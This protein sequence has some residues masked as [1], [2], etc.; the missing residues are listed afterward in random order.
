MI[1]D[2]SLRVRAEGFTLIEL[3]VVISIIAMLI[4]ILLPSMERARGSARL[5]LCMNNLRNIH[6]GTMMYTHDFNDRFPSRWSTGAWAFR[7]APGSVTPG[8]PAALPETFGWAAVLDHHQHLPW[9][10]SERIWTCP[11]Q[12]NWMKDFG[13]TYAFSIAGTLDNLRTMD[14]RPSTEILWDN[15]SIHPGLTGF[16]GPFRGY[17]IPVAERFY[18]HAEFV[19]PVGRASD[20][21][22][23]LRVNGSV[24]LRAFY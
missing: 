7:R 14:F 9:D 3:L 22:S 5:T 16:M 24:V 10:D 23:S 4:S 8:D 12:N 2:R 13:I 20:G 17:A 1:R 15:F 11:S 21:I 6:V 19:G 18:P